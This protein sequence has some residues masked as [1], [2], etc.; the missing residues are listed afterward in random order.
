MP[1]E[2]RELPRQFISVREAARICAISLSEAYKLVW[3]GEW[4][5]SRYGETKRRVL[6]HYDGLLAWVEWM[7]AEAGLRPTP[8][9]LRPPALGGRQ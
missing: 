7:K 5:S 8:I 2:Q 3:S 9:P 1:P 6:V 4:P